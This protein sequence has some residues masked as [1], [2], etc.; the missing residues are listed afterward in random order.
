LKRR[1]TT[2]PPVNISGSRIRVARLS[3]HPSTSQT[4]LAKQLLSKGFNIDQTALS[5]IEHGERGVMDVELQAIARLLKTTI[6]WLC[7]ER[8]ARR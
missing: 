5:R 8:G 6:A 7:G 2:K 4:A 3:Q 1:P